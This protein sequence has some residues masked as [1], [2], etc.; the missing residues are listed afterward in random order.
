M[1]DRRQI[2]K[3]ELLFRILVLLAA[4]IVISI[5]FVMTIKNDQEVY[6]PF[7]N[8]PMPDVCGIRSMLGV[9]CPGC[10]MSRAFISI[11]NL[12]INKALAFNSASLIVYLFVAIQIPWHATQIFMTFYRGGPIDTWW[13][14]LPPIGVIVWLLWC[15][16]KRS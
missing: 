7:T 6:T 11:S 12:E 8:G 15:Y 16:V 14:L 5:S 4:T 13:T 2:Y 9:D 1:P 10:G 3:P